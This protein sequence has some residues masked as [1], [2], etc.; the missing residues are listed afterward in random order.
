MLDHTQ[1][2]ATATERFLRTYERAR[3][4][5]IAGVLTPSFAALQAITLAVDVVSLITSPRKPTLTYLGY[6]GSAICFGLLI[7]AVIATRREQMKVAVATTLAASG[8]AIAAPSLGWAMSQGLGP[9]VLVGLSAYS[10]L[11]VLTGVLSGSVKVT[12]ATTLMSNVFSA[13]VLWG[14][15]PYQSVKGV[16]HA[17][18]WLYGPIVLAVQW[19]VALVLIAVVRSYRPT[20]YELSEA[21]QAN[22]RA[23][24]LDEIKDQFISSVNHE[25]RNPVMAVMGLLDLALEEDSLPEEQR[26]EFL[27]R[28]RNASLD[29]GAM[30]Q[31]ILDSRRIDQGAEDFVP[32]AIDL[33]AAIEAAERTIDPREAKRDG[34][35]VQIDIPEG[36][37][38]K[39]EPV[40]LRQIL[41][42]L[43]SNAIKYS[44]SGSPINISARAITDIPLTRGRPR[45]IPIA[46]VE[47]AIRDHGLGIPAEQIPLLFQRYVRL[48]RDLASTVTGNGL[49]LYLCRVLA[50][51][52]GGQIWVES[53]GVEGQGSTFF[54]KLPLA[55]PET[56]VP[57]VT[58]PVSS[59]IY[60]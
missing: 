16:F 60:P 15:A 53:S 5:K 14:V 59:K 41:N 38:I 52:M 4:L 33:R 29:L 26:H 55:T 58:V 51:A 17:E 27:V 1:P 28:A 25:L 30:L 12:I 54:V 3:V 37:A 9:A 10:V 49:G 57:V 7:I 45:S 34:H 22:E 13:L 23:R 21:R 42:N 40:R 31:G 2:I 19:A 24:Q 36:L 18:I 35:I 46:M 20:L 44:P 6:V 47:I 50:E 56:P 11:I 48:P 32:E 8:L 43:I 39:G